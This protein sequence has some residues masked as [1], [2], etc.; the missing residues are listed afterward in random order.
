MLDTK[1]SKVLRTTKKHL[2]LLSSLGV[3]TVRD[4]L[5]YY[6]RT[7]T[8]ERESVKVAEMKLDIPNVVCGKLTAFNMR[9]SRGGMYVGEGIISDETGSVPVIW[10][11]QKYLER[12]LKVGRQYYFSGKLK[13]DRGRSVFNGPKVE[14]VSKNL[15]HTGRIVPV[16]HQTEGLTSKWLRDKLFSILQ[17]SDD[18]EDKLADWIKEELGLC[19]LD[20]AIRNIHFPKS[21]KDLKKAQRRLAFDELFGLQL[22]YMERRKEWKS[23]NKGLKVERADEVMKKFAGELGFS[24]TQA[25]RRSLVEVLKDMDRGVPML[26]LVQGD[27]GS[28]KTVVA[29]MAALNVVKNGGQVAFMVP[30][31]VL[32]KQHDKELSY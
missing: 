18:F 20:F 24:L 2:A 25:Q 31:E 4:L 28:G 3:K 29:A 8:D 27:V 7:Y 15:L 1:L 12:I 5:E 16:Y 19:D 11:N 14:A 30:T 17:Y 21:E 32:A 22:E 26:R 6:P 23:S 9:K 10:F 13:Y